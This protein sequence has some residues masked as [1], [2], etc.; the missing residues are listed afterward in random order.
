MS[1][2]NSPLP[3]DAV[4]TPDQEPFCLT[5]AVL[6]VERAAA[7]RL[8]DVRATQRALNTLARHRLDAHRP[9]LEVHGRAEG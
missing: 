6:T 4:A 8:G 3:G 9:E 1:N 5:C 7:W 2:Q